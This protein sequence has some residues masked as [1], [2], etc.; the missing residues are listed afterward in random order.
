MG[1]IGNIW[2]QS[3]AERQLIGAATANVPM[4]VLQSTI[5]ADVAVLRAQVKRVD[6]TDAAI[7]L[8]SQRMLATVQDENS[9]GVGIAAP[10]VGVLASVIWVQR[11]DKDGRPFECYYNLSWKPTSNV[12]QKGPEGCLSI[13]NQRADVYRYQQIDIRY[14]TATGEWK[15]ENISGFTAVI[16][17]HE[18]DHLMGQWFTDHVEKQAKMEWELSDKGFISKE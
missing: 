17:Q 6:P 16:F 5:D 13:P 10:Q 7:Q 4:R 12:F 15:E 2:G 14:Q 8:L 18:G 9:K 3:D 1:M 11:F